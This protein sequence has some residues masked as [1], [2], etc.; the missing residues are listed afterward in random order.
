MGAE[1]GQDFQQNQWLWEQK[2]LKWRWQRVKWKRKQRWKQTMQGSWERE[3]GMEGTEAARVGLRMR[4]RFGVVLAKIFQGSQVDSGRHPGWWKGMARIYLQVQ[5][6]K[7]AQAGTDRAVQFLVRIRESGLMGSDQ[8]DQRAVD[9]EREEWG[10]RA[11]IQIC[12]KKVCG[13]CS[14]TKRIRWQTKD[15]SIFWEGMATN[16]VLCSIY[17]WIWRSCD[18]VGHVSGSLQLH[19]AMLPQ[20]S[21]Q[22][23][24]LLEDMYNIFFCQLSWWCSLTVITWLLL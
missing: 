11:T 3:W 13:T 16:M 21:P 8:L 2:G 6:Q 4:T 7:Q 18:R 19:M 9:G 14:N 17:I 15:H 22:A 23:S 10:G 20:A 24:Y 1:V 12:Q 5:V